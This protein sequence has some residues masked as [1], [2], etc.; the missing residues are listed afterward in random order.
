MIRADEMYLH[1]RHRIGDAWYIVDTSNQVHMFYLAQ[2]MLGNGKRFIGH[3]VSR[4][5]FE[6]TRLSPALH[7][8]KTGEWDDFQLCTGSIIECDGRYWMAYSA[9]DTINSPPDEPWRYQRTGMAVSDDFCIP[10]V[11][12]RWN[13]SANTGDLKTI[14]G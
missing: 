5:L 7:P 3:A 4:N 2:A 6:W 8:G 1:K 13:T 9:T 10:A 11:C 12:R 14:H